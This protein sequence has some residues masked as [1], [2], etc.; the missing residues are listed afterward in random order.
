MYIYVNFAVSDH[1]EVIS[2]Y[3]PY[4]L[5]HMDADSVSHM[6][7]CDHLITV[8]D[9]EAITAAP[10]DRMMNDAILQYVRVMDLPTLVKFIDLLKTIETQ[11]SVASYLK[12]CKYIYL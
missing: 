10:N 5:Q 8:D 4:L 11:K 3:Y 9:C 12:H 7:H 6:M 1:T 2:H